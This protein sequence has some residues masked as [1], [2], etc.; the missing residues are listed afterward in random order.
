MSPRVADPAIRTALIEAAAQVTATEGSSALTLRR[1]AGEVGTS[2]M[3]VYTH[4]GSMDELR[5]AVRVEG[6]ARLREHLNAV[7]DTGDPVAD[8]AH[9]GQAYYLTAVENPNLYR[10]MFM[11]GPVDEDDKET[12][13]ETF[14]R[15]VAGVQ[16]CMD[17]GR[18]RP[19]DP[20]ALA[21]QLWGLQHGMITLQF[22]HML[23]PDEALRG[24]LGAGY[25]LILAFGDDPRARP[26]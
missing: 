14:D 11:D 26:I 6:F 7:A 9:L 22:A 3:S 20:R 17:A 24:V 8:L 25:N 18:F 5:R 15:L 10:A 16:R 2:T 21:L 19:D 23:T 12:G 4:F 13:L 1:V